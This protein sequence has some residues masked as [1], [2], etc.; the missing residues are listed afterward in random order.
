MSPDVDGSAK[1]AKGAKGKAK[2]KLGWAAGDREVE[3]KGR[4][5]RQEAVAQAEKMDDG[6]VES[7]E[8]A[9]QEVRRSNE[10]ID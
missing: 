1:G 10:E 4:V 6:A 5:E 7:V 9:E 8:E 3:A 2:E